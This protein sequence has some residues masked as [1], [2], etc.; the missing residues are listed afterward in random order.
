VHTPKP[1]FGK[2]I[3]GVGLCLLGDEECDRDACQASETA[4]DE[5]L[6]G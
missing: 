1:L 5:T 2:P 6:E 3:E 4:R